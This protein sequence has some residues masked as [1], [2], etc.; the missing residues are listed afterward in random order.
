MKEAAQFVHRSKS[1]YFSLTT[2][3][4]NLTVYMVYMVISFFY[5]G[6]VIFALFLLDSIAHGEHKPSI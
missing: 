6:F 3:V 1:N 4:V 5:M 2:P